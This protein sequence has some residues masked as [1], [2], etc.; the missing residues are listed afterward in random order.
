MNPKLTESHDSGL[1]GCDDLSLKA[2]FWCLLGDDQALDHGLSR[3]VQALESGLPVYDQ[4]DRRLTDCQIKQLVEQFRQA[5]RL[6]AEL[7]Q[8]DGG[9]WA[10]YL[11]EVTQRYRIRRD[12]YSQVCHTSGS[13]TFPWLAAEGQAVTLRARAMPSEPSARQDFYVDQY[14][15]DFGR[16]LD[17]ACQSKDTR[18]QT[19]WESH[20]ARLDRWRSEVGGVAALHGFEC[21]LRTALAEYNRLGDHA[22]A[23]IA[24][25]L[26]DAFMG[27][28]ETSQWG[29]LAMRAW[30]EFR[31]NQKTPDDTATEPAHDNQ[32]NGLL[33]DSE[34]T[35]TTQQAR[36]NVLKAW[37]SKQELENST[38]NKAL[39]K[40]THAETWKMLGKMDK[41][42]FTPA[43]DSTVQKFFN[44]QKLCSFKIG[45]R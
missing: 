42:L 9:M 26:L 23:E 44:K 27:I 11:P 22:R 34:K 19:I 40:Y 28:A 30:A 10:E 32:A 45:R 14:L 15:N 38:F 35:V 4:A 20:L 41:A 1:V 25:V 31:L 21:G 24:E 33:L 16:W 12:D 13:D 17:R 2:S 39:I 3:F 36:E 8:G 7:A 43:S 29:V 37:I 6:W 18:E 5:A